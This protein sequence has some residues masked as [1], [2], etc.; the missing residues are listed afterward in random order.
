M[1]NGQAWLLER[2][3][4]ELQERVKMSEGATRLI[5]SARAASTLHQFMDLCR[6]VRRRR[7]QRRRT[8]SVH[9]GVCWR[10]G[11]PHHDLIN[12]RAKALYRAQVHAWVTVLMIWGVVKKRDKR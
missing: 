11:P 4:W 3:W 8:T 7:R 9:S 10:Q 1:G 6:S 5:H 2:W 12:A